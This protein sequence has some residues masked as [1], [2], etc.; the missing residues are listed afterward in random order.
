MANP[1]TEEDARQHL[2]RLTTVYTG[3]RKFFGECVPADLEDKLTPTKV[4]IEP[5][6]VRPEG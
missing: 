5:T 3:L 6:R 2:D 4:F 1:N